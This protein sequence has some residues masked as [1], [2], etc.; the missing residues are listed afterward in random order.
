MGPGVWAACSLTA[1]KVAHCSQWWEGCTPLQ[2][3]EPTWAFQE[4]QDAGN[5]DTALATAPKSKDNMGTE[6]SVSPP[7]REKDMPTLALPAARSH[8][9]GH[10]PVPLNA[11]V[12]PKSLPGPQSPAIF[13]TQE[14]EMEDGKETHPH[15]RHSSKHSPLGVAMLGKS[16]LYP[17]CLFFFFIKA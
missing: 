3:A 6:D 11:R 5:E 13:T 12:M 4:G 8:H 16:R 9:Q 14:P 7:L 10:P 15:F 17:S 1:G 2:E